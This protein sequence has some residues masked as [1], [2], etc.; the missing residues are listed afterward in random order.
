M[1]EQERQTD[2]LSQML[3]EA[4]VLSGVSCCKI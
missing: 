3:P 2:S 1:L 4:I